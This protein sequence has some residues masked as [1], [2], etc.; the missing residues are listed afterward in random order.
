[1]LCCTRRRRST[2]RDVAFVFMHD[3]VCFVQHPAARTV[4]HALYQRPASGALPR[5]TRC[6][7]CRSVVRYGWLRASSEHSSERHV[8]VTGVAGFLGFHAALKLATRGDRITGIDNFNAYYDPSLKRDRVRYLMR[9]APAVCIIELD[10]ADQKAVDELFASHRFTHV[11]HLAAQAGVRHSI[12]HPHCYIQS[13]CV[14]FLH[15]LEGVRN[16]RPQPPV[17]VYASSSSVYGLETQLPFRESMTADAPASL[18]AATKRANELMAFTYHHLYGLKATGLRYFTVYGPWGRPDMAYYAFAN[19]MHSGKPITLY[20]SGSAEPS[21]DFTYVDDAIDATVAALDRAYPWE[22]FNVGN[23]RMEP[24]SALVT[25]L[26]EAFGIVALKQHTGLQ[27][28]DVPATYA[29]IGKAKELLD[30]DP[31]TS[32]REGIKKFAAWYQWY[33]VENRHAVEAGLGI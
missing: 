26:E 18:Y 25:S 19:A 24:L 17:L 11:L 32:L 3:P 23:H 27:S 20:R 12:S 22:V 16:H 13:N 5:A 14:G 9:H 31:K 33:H 6:Y 10:L 28:G 30:Y 1:M 15:I 7:R 8:L 4:R 2:A 21:R 29:D